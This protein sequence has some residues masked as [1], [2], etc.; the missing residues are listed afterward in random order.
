MLTK[1]LADLEK[2]IDKSTHT[3]EAMPHLEAISIKLNIPLTLALQN[4]SAEI[5]RLLEV[6]IASRY[7]LEPGAVEASLGDD[8]SIK[9]ALDLFS[10]PDKYTAFLVSEK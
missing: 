10:S 5:K 2:S 9:K 8:P 6:D 1:D 3:E 4:N 7:Y